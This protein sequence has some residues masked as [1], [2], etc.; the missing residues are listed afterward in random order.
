M[1]LITDVP[2]KA[3]IRQDDK[4][5]L[6]QE[7][8]GRE[9]WALPG[10]RMNVGEQPQE[11]LRREIFEEIGVEITIGKLLDC[12]VFQSGSGMYH[13][14]V[15]FEA[16][17]AESAVLPAPDGQEIKALQWVTLE[18]ALK[19]KLRDEYRMILERVTL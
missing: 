11:G 5:L 19:L 17:L 3:L 14:V 9:G 16:T 7:T 18:E 4:I 12:A 2:L 10:G 6:V 1:H 15:V 13:F 8:E